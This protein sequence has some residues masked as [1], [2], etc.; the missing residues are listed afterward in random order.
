MFPRACFFH[1]SQQGAISSECISEASLS[2]NGH[3]LKGKSLRHAM[4][5]QGRRMHEQTLFFT[6][7]QN[8]KP[9][10][11]QT[12]FALN[13]STLCLRACAYVRAC[14]LVR[15]LSNFKDIVIS[16]RFLT[17]SPLV[18]FVRQAPSPTPTHKQQKT[19]N[20]WIKMLF[21]CR[22]NLSLQ[23]Y[24]PSIGAASANSTSTKNINLFVAMSSPSLKG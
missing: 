19:T 10:V 12:G 15:V 16:F 4:L 17:C 1:R 13:P 21:R 14:V 11:E 7:D 8:F 9:Q 2:W 18:S 23:R 3:H 20:I 22:L 24:T 6:E 5:C